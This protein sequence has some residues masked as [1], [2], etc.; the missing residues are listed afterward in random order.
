MQELE[1][2]WEV[3]GLPARGVLSSLRP[4]SATSPLIPL[5]PATE[6]SADIRFPFRTSGPSLRASRPIAAVEA[7]EK[8][9]RLGEDIS[10]VLVD[11]LPPG[12]ARRLRC[13]ISFAPREGG[14]A[15]IKAVRAPNEPGLEGGEGADRVEGLPKKFKDGVSKDEAEDAKKQLEEAGAEVTIV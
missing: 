10:G 9:E 12:E 7:P 15:V 13:G 1:F 4:F 14:Y 3:S 2:K 5:H 11:Y 8:I 6:L